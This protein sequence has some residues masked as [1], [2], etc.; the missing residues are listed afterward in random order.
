MRERSIGSRKQN[1]CI[2]G[3]LFLRSVKKFYSYTWEPDDHVAEGNL[4]RMTS[5][6]RRRGGQHPL[7][8]VALAIGF[9]LSIFL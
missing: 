3:D 4:A 9:A 5:C 7:P 1:A 6:Y 2:I 8:S